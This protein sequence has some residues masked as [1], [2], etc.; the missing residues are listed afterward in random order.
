MG[1]NL[2]ETVEALA[3]DFNEQSDS[4]T[5]ETSYKGSYTETLNAVT[6]AIGAGEAPEL[7]QIVDLGSRLAID[8]G[9]FVPMEEALPSDRIDWS[10]FQDPVIDYYSF[11]DTV[12]SLPFNSS[13]PIF[14]YNKDMFEEAGLDPESPPATFEEIRAASETVVSKGVAEQGITF[15]NVSWFPEQWFA[16]A[17]EPLVNEQ[18]GRAG[19]PTE[20]NLDTD[21]ASQIFSWW[22]DMYDEGLYNH[23]GV[24]AWGAAEQAFL[25][26]KTA[27][28]I[29]S[30]AGV[31]SATAGAEEKG[32]EL[33][34]GYYPTPGQTR[35]GVVI[36]GASLWMTRGLSEAKKQGLTDFLLWL[37]EAEQQAFWH[38]NT[39][40]FPISNSAVQLLED[41]G[42]F[43]EN[44]NF[45]TA[46][47]QLSETES[48]VATQGWQ[49]GP[50]TEVRTLIQDGYVSM[51]NSDVTIE[52]KLSSMKSEADTVLREYIDSKG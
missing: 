35:T 3:S 21:V 5:V 13:N 46:F 26:G 37:S 40:Y 50:A 1:G 33:G 11:D 22:S 47:D 14:Y 51:I 7:A 28:W 41:E 27:M 44:P 45:Q 17:G 30:T 4:V 32:F 48:S 36:G 49:A 39:G 43:D 34:T 23:A 20:I 15:A 9:A 24:G 10:D 31:A 38:R 52:E 12:H 18:N 6:S 2:G 8:S 19:D 42:W 29:S 16:E 25:N